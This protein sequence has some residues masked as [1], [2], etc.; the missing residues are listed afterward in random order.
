MCVHLILY[1]DRA[2][3][4]KVEP[5]FFSLV[6]PEGINGPDWP[7]RG[8]FSWALKTTIQLAFSEIFYTRHQ[9]FWWNAGVN[10]ARPASNFVEQVVILPFCGRGGLAGVR[11]IVFATW[12]LTI[13]LIYTRLPGTA[14]CFCLTRTARIHQTALVSLSRT[15]CITRMI[16]SLGRISKLFFALKSAVVWPFSDPQSR[17]GH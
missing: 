9:L 4:P 2:R 6:P 14:L 17:F 13:H 3:C 16:P 8:Y 12:P 10:P 15:I 1:G 7:E 11:W 5:W